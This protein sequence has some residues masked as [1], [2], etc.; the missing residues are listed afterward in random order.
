MFC[1]IKSVFLLT[2]TAKINQ[3]GYLSDVCRRAY[4]DDL[5]DIHSEL[6]VAHLPKGHPVTEAAFIA[7]KVSSVTILEAL[8]DLTPNGMGDLLV[9]P[10]CTL[11]EKSERFASWRDTIRIV[12]GLSYLILIIG[13]IA[14]IAGR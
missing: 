10:N 11:K 9:D 2:N 13:L 1:S 6:S 14:L 5:K 4:L 3:L 8:L 12:R 7:S